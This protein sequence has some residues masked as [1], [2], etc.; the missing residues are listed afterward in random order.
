[1]TTE[2]QEEERAET[3]RLHHQALMR[4]AD[5]EKE[6][7]LLRGQAHGTITATLEGDTLYRDGLR[8][9]EW[10]KHDKSLRIHVDGETI[11]GCPDGW[12]PSIQD[13]EEYVASD[14]AKRRQTHIDRLFGQSATSQ[15]ERVQ[16][17]PSVRRLNEM[18]SKLNG[19]GG[20]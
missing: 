16:E 2:T 19:G 17:S 8:A 7:A 10:K 5:A 12:P 15:D 4:V 18:V 6:I 13:P 3:Q 20:S 9:Q 1:M 11:V 14:I